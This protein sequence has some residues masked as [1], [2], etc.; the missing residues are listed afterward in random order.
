MSLWVA[1]PFGVAS[2]TVY[3]TSIVAQHRAASRHADAD[4]QASAAG[5]LRLVRDPTFLMAIGGDGVGFALQIVALALGVVVVI[6]PLVVLMLPVALA[7]S[8]L[9]GRRRPHRSE[10]LG[11]AGVLAGLAVFLALV[12]RPAAEHVPDSRSLAIAVVAVLLAGIV[13]VSAVTGR[14]ARVR[15]A[16]YG[17]VAGMYFGL[18]AVMVDAASQ[19]ASEA[20]VKALFT[21]GR[22]LVPLVGILL[23]GAGGIVLTQ[24]SFQVGALGATL[25]ASLAADPLT[26]VV[27]GALLLAERIPHTPIDVLVY[28][29]CLAAVVAGAIR[30]ANPPQDA[31]EAGSASAATHLGRTDEPDPLTD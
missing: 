5:L 6:Q 28:V 30:L 14:S 11:C 23:L 16:M 10:L 27:F 12:G 3:G 15:G 1:V 29:A 9:I 20:G 17:G 8:S 31:V 22:G 25:P 24:M 4:G 7:V 18:L 19:R 2:A 13:L 21:D 26:G